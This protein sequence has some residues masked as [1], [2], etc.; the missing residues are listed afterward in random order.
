MNA[1]CRRYSLI[2]PDALNSKETDLPIKIFGYSGKSWQKKRSESLASEFVNR[3][4]KCQ[5]AAL[6]SYYT[7]PT[8]G[9]ISQYQV[10][11]FLIAVLKRVLPEAFHK[12]F[13][14]MRNLR[15]KLWVFLK[16]PRFEKMSVNELIV[17]VSLKAI[18]PIFDLK[19]TNS[20]FQSL[21]EHE[22]IKSLFKNFMH[23]LFESF[24]I[25]LLRS[26]FYITEA[27]N[28]RSRLVFYRHDVWTQLTLPVIES[29][30]ESMFQPIFGNT[31]DAFAVPVNSLSKARCRLVPKDNGTFRPIM[32]FKKPP[33]TV[34]VV[35]FVFNF[36]FV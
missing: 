13:S 35:L 16:M 20:A 8:K 6:Y 11:G 32:A 21:S 2:Y 14:F 23:F 31:S 7:K 22:K 28:S 25:E 19:R 30:Q 5:Y 4:K 1:I 3:H 12:N 24:L 33:S 15:Q 27:A 18:A 10:F 34:L 36:I 29:L 9:Q 26:N 17:G